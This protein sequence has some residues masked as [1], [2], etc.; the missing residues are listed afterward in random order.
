MIF[1]FPLNEAENGDCVRLAKHIIHFLL[2]A[3]LTLAQ[4]NAE[5]LIKLHFN[6]ADVA[7][8]V[9]ADLCNS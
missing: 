2:P 3:S 6:W 4:I 8:D 9:F 1:S 5:S 7:I